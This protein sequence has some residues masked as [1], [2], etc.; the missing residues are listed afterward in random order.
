[1][2]KQENGRPLSNILK[3]GGQRMTKKIL[4]VDDE[5]GIRMLLK[6]MFLDQGYHVLT[7]ETGVKG[8][9]YIETNQIDLLIIDYRL[10]VMDGMEVLAHLKKNNHHIPVIMISGLFENRE[11]TMSEP[12][13]KA[14]FAKPFN[15]AELLEQVM[16][17]LK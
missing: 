12:L 13:V 11:Q 10:P 2:K 1:M 16:S 8:L 14:V 5:H 6:E 15:I 7:A 9:E 17:I 4:V 3:G